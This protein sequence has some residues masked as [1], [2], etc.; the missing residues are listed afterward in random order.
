MQMIYHI[1]RSDTNFSKKKF[2]SAVI[3]WKKLDSRLRKVKSITN[4]RKNIL[5]FIKPKENSTFN[6]NSLKGMKFVTRFKC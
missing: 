5:S 3:E 6:C 4:F 1:L 2:T